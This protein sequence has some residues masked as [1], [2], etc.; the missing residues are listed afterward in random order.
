VVAR[1]SPE[2]RRALLLL[3]LWL[4]IAPVFV[5]VNYKVDMIG[6]HLFFTMLPVALAGGVM[7]FQLSRGGRW[8]ATLAALAFATIGWQGLVFWV[9]RLVRASS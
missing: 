4:A 9:E 6:K 1:R 3:I 5:L 7:L 2:R 8:R